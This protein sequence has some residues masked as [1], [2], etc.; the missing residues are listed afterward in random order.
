MIR[1]GALEL[2]LRDRSVSKQEILELHA[3]SGLRRYTTVFLPRN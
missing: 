3:A 2:F 1:P